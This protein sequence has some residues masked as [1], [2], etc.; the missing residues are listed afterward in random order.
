[1]SK[2]PSA[3]CPVGSGKGLAGVHPE[4]QGRGGTLGALAQA[5]IATVGLSLAATVVLKTGPLGTC[6]P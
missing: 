5:G 2:P 6:T 1:M 3:C 4:S